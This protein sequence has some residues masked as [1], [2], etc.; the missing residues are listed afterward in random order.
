MRRSILRSSNPMFRVK[1]YNLEH[2]G[3]SA[4][5]A[6]IVTKTALLF[7][8]LLASVITV[9]TYPGLF[10]NNIGLLLG[11]AFGAF[12]LVIITRFNPRAAKFTA[13]LYAILEGI[14]IGMIVMAYELYMPGLVSTAVV[15]T[16][17]IFASMLILYSTGVIR[18][19]SFLRRLVLSALSGLILFSFVIF[20]LSLFGSSIA[21]AFFA[22]SQFLLLFSLVSA[23]I[24]TL[25]ILLDLDNC[26][27]IVK[28][29]APK[30]YE[31]IA[32][33]GLMVTLIWLFLE[34]LRIL[35]I[36]AS[37]RD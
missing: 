29:N 9:N 32:S 2:T 10:I 23:V 30:E 11:S 12:I 24:A 16:L 19:G 37:R 34:V 33:L 22:N 20:M 31:W 18:V 4:T 15:V 7:L 13:P 17:S 5:Y 28:S 1:N 27:Y 14:V 6:G 3:E 26:T 36:F 25:M 21:A 35:A 8:G